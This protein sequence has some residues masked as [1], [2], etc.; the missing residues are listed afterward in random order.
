MRHGKW[1]AGAATGLASMAMF[2]GAG[3]AGG[4]VK[5]YGPVSSGAKSTVMFSGAEWSKD[6]SYFYS[7][8]IY[9]LNRDLGRDGILLRAYGGSVDY[10]YDDASVAGGRVDGDGIQGD[11]MIGYIWHLGRANFSAYVGVDYQKYDLSPQ[12]ALPGV[13]GSEVGFK[14]AADIASAGGPLYYTLQA[15]YSTAFDSYWARARIGYDAG[16]F[17]IGPEAIALGNESFDAQR[18]GGF[19]TLRFELT[20]G[21]LSEVTGYA[22]YQFVD[23]DNNGTRGSTGGGEG[24]YGGIGFTMV[25]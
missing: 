15:T 23:D 5:D 24:A 12:P 11:A 4:S 25:F 21:I 17:V 3:I 19:A 6:A 13:D 22:G 8:V 7:G 9:A 18:I 14:V 10:E 16:R 20:P 1:F 2:A